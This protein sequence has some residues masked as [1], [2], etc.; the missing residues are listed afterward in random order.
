VGYAEEIGLDME[1]F[2]RD[3]VSDSVRARIRADA[4]EAKALGVTGTPSFFVNGRFLSGAQPIGSFKRLI[5]EELS[6][7]R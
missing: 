3:W 7:T 5:D 1:R 2:R 4:E 6:A